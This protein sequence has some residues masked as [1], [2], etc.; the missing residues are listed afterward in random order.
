MPKQPR[1]SLRSALW[2]RLI[3]LAAVV[4]FALTAVTVADQVPT[5]ES[6]TVVPPPPGVPVLRFGAGSTARTQIG[7]MLVEGAGQASLSSVEEPRFVLGCAALWGQAGQGP[8]DTLGVLA[9]P[10][11]PVWDPIFDR[12]GVVITLN[13]NP[14]TEEEK[15]EFENQ[16]GEYAAMCEVLTKAYMYK[17]SQ[18]AAE[19]QPFTR[20]ELLQAPRRHRGDVVHVEGSLRRVIRHEPP[21]DIRPN[22]V[23]DVYEGWLFTNE[24]VNGGTGSWCVYFTELP[25]GL[26]PAESMNHPAS[27]DGYFVKSVG[28]TN[29]TGK[30]L[31]A[32]MLVGN[33]P[34]LKSDPT[35]IAEVVDEMTKLGPILLYGILGVIVIVL[36]LAVVLTLWFRRGDARVRQKL[37]EI[38]ARRFV[39]PAVEPPPEY[40]MP[41]LENEASPPDDRFAPPTN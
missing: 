1:H 4:L 29:K 34:V 30:E 5:D 13:P 32:P 8:L 22:G 21:L 2:V 33:R 40:Q 35:V 23:R 28:Y 20:S 16:K 19:A 18:F 36:T 14:K 24:D 9:T 26:E 11:R 7:R 31:T 12:K 17:A 3:V 25:E 39:D 41:P 10:I 15:R 27:F 38:T 6:S 37:A